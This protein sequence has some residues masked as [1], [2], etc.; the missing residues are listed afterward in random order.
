MLAQLTKASETAQ[1]ELAQAEIALIEATARQQDAY[2]EAS[3]LQAAVAA[4]K[5][6]PPSAAL[7]PSTEGAIEGKSSQRSETAQLSAE[8]F[9]K[10]RKRRQRKR[11][12]ELDAENPLAHVKCS[13]CGVLGSLVE[14]YLQA[15]SGAPVRM[16]V[17]SKCNNQ[18]IQ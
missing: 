17:C 1:S 14:T 4:L 9:D 5:G 13:G 18:L 6:E 2:K 10:E 8:E 15:P 11:Q 12:K 16:L 3:K 7:T